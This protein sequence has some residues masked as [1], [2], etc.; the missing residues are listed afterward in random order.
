ML[1]PWSQYLHL[2][3]PYTET[4]S[5]MFNAICLFAF[6]FPRIYLLKIEEMISSVPVT[7]V[8]QTP[9][10]LDSDTSHQHQQGFIK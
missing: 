4:M 3:T 6:V 7:V 5:A 1:S 9:K 10:V 8:P 2:M